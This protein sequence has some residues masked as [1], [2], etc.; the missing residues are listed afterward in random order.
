MVRVGRRGEGREMRDVRIEEGR[1]G[2]GIF[3]GKECGK[4]FFREGIGCGK[5]VW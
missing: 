4:E 1:G 2:V 5:M 3:S